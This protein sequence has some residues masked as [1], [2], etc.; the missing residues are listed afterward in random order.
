MV[1]AFDDGFG[2]GFGYG[3]VF[4]FVGF[5]DV[6]ERFLEDFLAVGNAERH[7]ERVGIEDGHIGFRLEGRR[8]V[9]PEGNVFF[10]DVFGLEI[11]EAAVEHDGTVVDDDDPVADFLDVADVVGSEEDRGVFRPVDRVDNVPEIGFGNHVEPD[12]RFVEKQD[13]WAVDEAR[14]EF[15]PHS[16]PEGQLPYGNMEQI[17]HLERF[18][19]IIKALAELFVRDIVHLAEELVGVDGREVVVEFGNLAEYR[20]DQVRELA[21]IAQRVEP[22]DFQLPAAGSEDAAEHLDG[23]G[24]SR[25]VRAE[26]GDFFSGPNG[27]IEIFY[28][29]EGLVLRRENITPSL[30]LEGDSE[31][32]A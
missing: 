3:N 29:V 25:A 1:E 16:L 32:F 28:R 31:G 6:R 11:M 15:R 8:R 4:Y 9:E 17:S 20:S 2:I 22:A 30:G 24:F 10:L 26:E 14:D 23:G 18:E 21:P 27:E 19:E 7:A 13:F 5:D 12:G